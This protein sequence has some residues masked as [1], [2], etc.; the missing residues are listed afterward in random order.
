MEIP[1]A[2]LL[3]AGNGHDSK[4]VEDLAKV[5]ERIHFLGWLEDVRKYFNNTDYILY[6]INSERK[7]FNY[8]APNTL[9]LSISHEIPLITNVPGEAESLIKN[10]KIGFFIENNERLVDKIELNKQSNSYKEMVKNLSNIRSEF[11]WS[12]SFDIYSKIFNKI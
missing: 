6:F 1:N 11:S 12:A 9:Y 3:I 5:N 10:N 2:H 8:A 4:Y 7:Y